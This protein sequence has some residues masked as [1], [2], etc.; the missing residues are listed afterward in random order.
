MR[1]Q[2]ARKPCVPPRRPASFASTILSE[3]VELT[4]D[5]L[6]EFSLSSISK[7]FDDCFRSSMARYLGNRDTDSESMITYIWAPLQLKIY[8]FN[9]QME[10]DKILFLERSH[11]TDIDLIIRPE[12]TH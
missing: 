10:F 2:F 8:F 12:G 3:I 11:N 6:I 1:L 9:F 5:D 7:V 4:I